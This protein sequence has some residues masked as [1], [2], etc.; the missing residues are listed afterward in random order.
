MRHVTHTVPVL[1]SAFH[2]E[3]DVRAEIAACLKLILSRPSGDVF[4]GHEIY[5][6]PVFTVPLEIRVDS[7]YRN[8]GFLALSGR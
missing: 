1:T 6:K 2:I 8:V 7:K 3:A 5:G 4:Y